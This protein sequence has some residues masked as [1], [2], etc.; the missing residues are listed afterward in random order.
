MSLQQG[1]NQ[2]GQNLGS[3]GRDLIS[4]AQEISR[5]IPMPRPLGQA[6]GIQ[7]YVVG[8]GLQLQC[9]RE[10]LLRHR[11]LALGLAYPSQGIQ[12]FSRRFCWTDNLQQVGRIFGITIARQHGGKFQRGAAMEGALAQDPLYQRGNFGS[13][14]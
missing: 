12:I 7:K 14:A 6:G 1:P 3:I 8:L 11:R 10:Q 9:L 13:F 4:P 2:L 5:A